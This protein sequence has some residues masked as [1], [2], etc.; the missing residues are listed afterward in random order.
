MTGSQNGH[1][2]IEALL[3]ENRVFPPSHG[4]VA[5]ANVNSPEIYTEAAANLEGFWA[6]EAGKL[7]WFEPCTPV[8]DWRCPVPNGSSA[9]R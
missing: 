5:Q 1:E 9:A 2:G 4:F 6:G 7:D 8:L 3:A